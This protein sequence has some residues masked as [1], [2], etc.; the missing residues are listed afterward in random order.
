M[1]IVKNLNL[2]MGRFLMPLSFVAILGGMI[3]LIGSSTN[4]LVS[5]SLNKYSNLEI[6]FFDFAIPGSIIA[7]AGLLYVIIFS[8]YFLTD[9]SPISNQLVKDS[10]NNF[11]TQIILNDKSK[12][13]G[14]TSKGG[15]FEGLENIKILM[16]QRGEHAEH[17]PNEWT[18]R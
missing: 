12:L 8:R 9:R 10:K 18:D 16:I 5:D 6:S 3:T 11:I 7:F 17:C 1:F 14:Q 2:S 4:L 15:K 13:I